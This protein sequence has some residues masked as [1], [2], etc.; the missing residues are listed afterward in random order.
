MKK[1]IF[2]RG[3]LAAVVLSALTVC[4]F[5]ELKGDESPDGGSSDTDV[6]VI[7]LMTWNVNNLFDGEDNGFEY[8]EYSQSAGWSQ[9]KYLGRVNVI[10]AAIEKIEPL[11]DI[12]MFQEIESLNIIEDL[13]SSITDGGY[14]WSHFANNPGAALGVGILSRFPLSDARVHTVTA[15]DDTTPRPVL[16][17]RLQAREA[18]FVVFVCH[19]KSK[20][21]GDDVTESVRR[22]S[23]SVIV[24][25]SR[26]LW[27][28]EP[29]LGVIAAGDLNEN[30]DEFFRQG[31]SMICALLPDDPYCARFT[32]CIDADEGDAP[33]RQRDFIVI[34]K[35]KPPEP[36]HFPQGTVVLFSPWIDD[37]EPGS[38]FYK[39][40]WETID[41]FLI[42]GQFFDN[43]AWDYEKAETANFS[44]FV[45][46][47]GVPVAYNV[48]TG[49]GLSDHLPLLLTLRFQQQ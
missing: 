13:A 10:S 43:D 49:S 37:L 25:R 29:D 14:L 16:E 2:W 35:K 38:Y 33:E 48:R 15:G 19:W 44:P 23:A 8:E 1:F 24:R 20:L 41:H 7:T 9:E 39:Y 27:E 26:E 31:A 36:V 18:E 30:H 42:S 4:A 45:N 3:V 32:G 21:G 12:I 11:P 34:S 46:A 40:N 17:V 5:C 6:D 28:N 22:A 47:N